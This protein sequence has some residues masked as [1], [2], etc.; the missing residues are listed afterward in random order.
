MPR[1]NG[2]ELLKRMREGSAGVDR[3]LPVA[4]LTGHGDL[5]L[6]RTAMA[7]D[8][9]AFLTKPTSVG[10]LTD[11]LLRIRSQEMEIKPSEAYAAIELPKIILLS[12]GLPAQVRSNPVMVPISRDGCERRG[13]R[14]VLERVPPN[15]RLA[16]EVVGPDGAVLRPVATLL[17]AR[18]LTRTRA[19]R[20]S[21]SSTR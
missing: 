19:E 7:L 5:S 9:N 6:V 2:L 18:L 13:I 1:L 3:H 21:F 11:R 20:K 14:L 17:T 4:M 16:R 10:V 8:V 12:S 15:A